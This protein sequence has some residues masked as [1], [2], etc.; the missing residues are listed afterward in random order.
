MREEAEAAVWKTRCMRKMVGRGA[1]ERGG[2]EMMESKG[3]FYPTAH[4]TP[5]PMSCNDTINLRT[6]LIAAL[7]GNIKAALMNNR[8]YC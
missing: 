1:G 6:L 4:L 8:Q 2:M 7:L 3:T 5:P